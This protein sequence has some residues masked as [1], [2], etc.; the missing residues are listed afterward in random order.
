MKKAGHK[1][2]SDQSPTSTDS[3][4]TSLTALNAQN[5]YSPIMAGQNPI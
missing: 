5:I 1:V 4:M 2:G 3:V